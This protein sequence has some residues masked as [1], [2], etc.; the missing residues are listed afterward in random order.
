MGGVLAARRAAVLAAGLFLLF[1]ATPEARAFEFFDGRLQ[2][3]GFYEQQIRF[4][5]EDINIGE[6]MDLA[7][8]Y[9]V[10]NLEIEGDIAPDGFGPFDLISS[11]VRVEARFDCIWSHGCGLFRS[12][13]AYGDSVG[14]IPDVRSDGKRAG[15]NGAVFQGNQSGPLIAR[16]DLGRFT[17]RRLRPVVD[18]RSGDFVD[19]LLPENK[20]KPARIDQLPG[21]VGLFGVAGPD[22]QFGAGQGPFGRD[23]PAYFYFQRQR[24]CRFGVR[25]TQGGALGNSNQILILNP[26]CG[27]REVGRLR[28]F[29]NPFSDGDFNEVTG[30]TGKGELP[31]RP[32]PLFSNTSDSP[33]YEARGVYYPSKS[34]KRFL[35]GGKGNDPDQDFRE[36]ELQW[37]RGASQQDEK[38]LKEAYLDIEMFDSRLWLRLGKQS[39]VWGKTEL[40]R[41]TDQYNPQ[42][43]ALASLPSLEESRISLWS[44][45]GVW[46]FWEV[47]PA[48][49]VRIEVAMNFDQFEPADI[50]RCGEPFTALAA[51]AKTV[52]LWAHGLT[53]FGL[54]GE[55]RPDDPWDDVEGIEIGARLEFRLGRFSFQVSNFYGY[56]DL[57][58]ADTI[59]LYERNVDP[60][61]GRARKFNARGPC[62]TGDEPSCLG[63]V[64]GVNRFELSLTD[65]SPTGIEDN[66]TNRITDPTLRNEVLNEASNNIQLFAMICATSIGFSSLDT[67]ACGQSVFNSLNNL[68][69]Q[70]QTFARENAKNPGSL[71]ISSFLANGAAGNPNAAGIFALLAGAVPPTVPINI[72]PCDQFRTDGCP[73]K[74]ATGTAVMPDFGPHPAFTVPGFASLN[75]GLTDEQ[76]A[77]LGCG[78]FYG[79]DC[80]VDGI[81]L[82]QAEAATYMQSFVGT[83]M[84]IPLKGYNYMDSTQPAPGTV[85]SDQVP[86]QRRFGQGNVVLPGDRGEGNAGYDPLVDG[87]TRPGAF[88]CN[89][90]DNLN[91]VVRPADALELRIPPVFT[92]AGGQLFRSEMAAVSFNIQLGLAALS[93]SPDTAPPSP[94]P[95]PPHE[96]NEFNTEDPFDTSPQQ[97]SWAQPQFCGSQQALFDVSGLR[98][99]SVR[100]AGNGTHGRRDFAWNA[101]GQ[102]VLRY[103][104]RNV[105]GFSMDFA[106]DVTKSN[107]GFEATWI[108]GVPF[109]DNNSLSGRTTADTY[110]L[111]IS[112]DRPTFVNFLNQNR[113]FFINTQWFIQYVDDYRRGFTSNGPWNV[114]GT[115]TIQTGYFQDRLLPSFT[116]VYD[117]Q[118]QSGAALP[119]ITYRFTE[120]FSLTIGTNWFWGNPQDRDM[121]VNGGIGGG[122]EETGNRAYQRGVE[123]GLALVRERDEAFLRLRYAF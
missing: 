32:R 33:R 67:S 88:G 25:E 49:D 2:I 101:G 40:F 108:E 99:K 9:H 118:S 26:R 78:I 75:Q 79:T 27:A 114:L 81:D 4:L 51:C 53:G 107:W 37:N 29:P 74:G 10:L 6:D 39:I 111:T 82:L 76:E 83:A 41:T 92:G 100:A 65:G 50:G 112:V 43:L 90:G 84:T 72:D 42:D 97:C 91:G 16:G 38:E 110:N 36:N 121:G 94:R 56:N 119:Q 31:A 69:V 105:L 15:L 12:V 64:N 58:Y 87:C 109:S 54:A 85:G 45:R 61:S 52:G 35:R 11:F 22:A 47:G 48:E 1:G 115:L 86:A 21:F 73:A 123:N 71:P 13:D 117:T 59:T 103:E 3:H 62:L 34:F 24:K 8:W 19:A 17:G 77:L 106:E 93:S 122:G 14:S 113:T 63:S 66:G 60:V 89:A 23:D 102:A 70:G 20:N 46:S 95:D 104:K 80:E 116:L 55:Q 18:P 98:R 44:A 5:G 96:L 30:T 57:P 28:D 120:N 68:L 7:Q